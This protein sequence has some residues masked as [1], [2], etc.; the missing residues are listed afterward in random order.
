MNSELVMSMTNVFL[1]FC[2]STN[3]RPQEMRG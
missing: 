1:Y 2:S 3:L